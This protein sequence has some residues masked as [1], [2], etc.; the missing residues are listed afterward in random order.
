MAR[1]FSGDIQITVSGTYKNTQQT[2]AQTKTD[3]QVS[4]GLANAIALSITNGTGIDQAQREWQ[5]QDRTLASAGTLTLDVFDFGSEDIGG[6]AGNDALGQSLALTGVKLLL[7]RNIV[8]ASGGILLVGGEGSAAAWNSPFNAVDTSLVPVVQGG[9]LVMVAPT[10]AGYAVADASNHL[11]KF[12][13]SGGACDFD[14][15]IIGI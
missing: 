13:A 2:D 6:G 15:V 7:V 9:I 4:I 10:A 3:P 5:S 12:E 1:E 11:L 14:I 8:K